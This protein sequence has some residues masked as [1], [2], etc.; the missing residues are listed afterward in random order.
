MR[1]GRHRQLIVLVLLLVSL[2]GG[3][4]SPQ[5]PATSPSTLT[6]PPTSTVA[7]PTTKPSPTATPGTKPTPTTRA[8]ATT[9]PPVITSTPLP[10]S[11]LGAEW[12]RL[13]TARKVVAL[14]F[15][16]GGDAGGVPSILATLAA[17]DT[18]ATFFATGRW[19]ARYPQRARAI[20]AHYPLGNHT[21]THPDLTDLGD[22]AVQRELT[23]AQGQ[24][25]EAT[26]H[27]AR[28]LFRFPYGASDPR[29]IGIVNSLGY[30]AVRWTV[31]TLG[32]KGTSGGQSAATVVRRVLGGLRPGAIV[33]L[34]V[35]ANPQDGS[36]L[37]ADA[38]PALIS[39]LRGRG[40]GFATVSQYL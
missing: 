34:H 32:W 40:Y 19:A 37:D 17:T 22:Q 18:P 27:D 26:A 3:C 31:D 23:T 38:L 10:A 2:A 1:Q 30:G 13:P 4:R 9:T 20:A 7:P 5:P 29:T 33:L 11:L 16:A 35:G 39:Q 12:T 24:I 14:T 36:T 6:R 28:P 15:D 8:P 25:L 21:Q